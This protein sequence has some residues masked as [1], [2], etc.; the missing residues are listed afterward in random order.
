MSTV[1]PVGDVTSAAS[2]CPTSMKSTRSVPAAEAG[3]ERSSAA[4]S[5]AE[6]SSSRRANELAFDNDKQNGSNGPGG[7]DSLSNGRPLRCPGTQ[8][9]P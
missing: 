4:P 5:R 6:A 1:F 3:I 2:P 8:L 9:V 7:H